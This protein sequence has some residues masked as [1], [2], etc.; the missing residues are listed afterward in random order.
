LLCRLLSYHAADEQE[1]TY[2]SLFHNPNLTAENL[3]R[4]D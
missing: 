3:D 4:W 2:Q 1:N